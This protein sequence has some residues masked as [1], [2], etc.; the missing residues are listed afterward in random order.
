MPAEIWVIFMWYVQHKLS[1]GAHASHHDFQLFITQKGVLFQKFQVFLES[2]YSH[3][4]HV[5][6]TPLS[7]WSALN[8][9]KSLRVLTAKYPENE[10]RGS[11]RPVNWTSI[12]YMWSI[13]SLVELR[14]DNTWTPKILVYS[15]SITWRCYGN[16]Q[17][18]SVK[19]L[20]Q[21]TR[22]F[23]KRLPFSLTKSQKSC[24]H[25]WKPHTASVVEVTRKS[26]IL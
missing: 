11:C 18:M 22:N 26:P 13:E 5:A 2:H 23:W 24:W 19:W 3:P 6:V 9:P 17:R 12:F 1:C 16:E 14:S 21:K 20:K 15:D 8:T 4:L 7:H 25:T 10:A